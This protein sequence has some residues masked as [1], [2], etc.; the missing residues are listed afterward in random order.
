MKKECIIST[1]IPIYNA[2]EYLYN[3]L[4]SLLVQHVHKEN[5]EILLIDD[6]STDNSG[7]ICDVYSKR[8]N[9]VETYHLKNCGVSNARNFGLYKASG[10]YIHFMDSDDILYPNI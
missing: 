1:I 10:K 7:K 2:E 5:R 8:Y 4:N 3:T 6:G 9:F